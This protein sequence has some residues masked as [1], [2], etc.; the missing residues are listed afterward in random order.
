[1]KC[2]ILMGSPRKQGNTRQLLDPFT[3]E[4]TALGWETETVG[5]YDLDLRP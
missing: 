3:A 4:L 2:L 1:M 5:L